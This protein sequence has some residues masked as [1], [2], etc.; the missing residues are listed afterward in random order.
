M[1]TVGFGGRKA[2]TSPRF[3][4]DEARVVEEGIYLVS[5]QLLRTYQQECAH[6]YILTVLT[7]LTKHTFLKGEC[8]LSRKQLIIELEFRSN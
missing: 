5:S 6:K 7:V 4:P 2:M 3:K 1:S 8:K